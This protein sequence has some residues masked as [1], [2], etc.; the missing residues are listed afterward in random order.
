MRCPSGSRPDARNRAFGTTIS[1][2]NFAPTFVYVGFWL[3]ILPLSV[4]FGN[5]WSASLAA[6][7][8]A[9]VWLLEMGGRRH[10]LCWS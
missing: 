2:L 10:G 9:A 1:L 4:L 5:V 6:V 8:D 7:A 3:R